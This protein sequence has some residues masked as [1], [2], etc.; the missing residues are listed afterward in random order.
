M[1]EEEAMLNGVTSKAALPLIGAAIL[2]P[3]VSTH[4]RAREQ[5]AV[6]ALGDAGIDCMA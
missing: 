3:C 4:F 5:P 2:S 6:S 1:P